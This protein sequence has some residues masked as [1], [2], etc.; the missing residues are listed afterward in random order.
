[1][2]ITS[3]KTAQ[4]PT[5]AQHDRAGV[6]AERILGA[7]TIGGRALAIMQ[8]VIDLR[9]DLKLLGAACRAHS[10]ER[11]FKAPLPTE[12]DAQASDMRKEFGEVARLA[13]NLLPRL[14]AAKRSGLTEAQQNLAR[15]AL[16]EI[17]DDRALGFPDAEATKGRVNELRSVL[18]PTEHGGKP[19]LQSELARRYGP[20]LITP[21]GASDPYPTNL[22]FV[23]NAYTSAI[24]LLLR[25]DE[26]RAAQ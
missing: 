2:A 15:T 22:Q 4:G 26:P 20:A 14:I 1:M 11:F 10:I 9:G 23:T 25:S 17:E 19:A 18:I 21:S 24:S 7:S 6:A 13:A 5:G 8:G 16:R 12:P 3:A